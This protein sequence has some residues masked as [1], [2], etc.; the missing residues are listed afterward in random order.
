M[1][2]GGKLHKMIKSGLWHKIEYIRQLAITVLNIGNKNGYTEKNEYFSMENVLQ[3]LLIDHDHV[4][5]MNKKE[6]KS[7]KKRRKRE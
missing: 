1:L 3:Q 7:E 2:I 5:A 4:V 6:F